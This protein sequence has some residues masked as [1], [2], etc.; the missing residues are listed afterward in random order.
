VTELSAL[1][2]AVLVAFLA[3]GV[4]LNVL[5]EEVPTERRSRFWAFALGMAGYAALLLTL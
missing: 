5:K 2:V 1:A 4:I 3:G